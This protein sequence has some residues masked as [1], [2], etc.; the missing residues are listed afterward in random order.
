[1][2]QLSLDF[3]CQLWD[4]VAIAVAS[5]I[6]YLAAQLFTYSA[7]ETQGYIRD[8]TLKARSE[9]QLMHDV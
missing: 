4:S 5:V 2:K 1:M 7:G 9:Q 8:D 3:I 6:Y